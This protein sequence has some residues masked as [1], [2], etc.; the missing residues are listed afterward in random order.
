[1]LSG[2]LQVAVEHDVIP[3][4]PV[5]SLRKVSVPHA[6]EKVP[7]APVELEALV[8]GFRGR[9]RAITV[10]GGHLGLSPIEIRLAPWGNLAPGYSTLLIGAGKTKKQRAHSR[11]IVIPQATAVELRRWRMESGRPAD[12]EPII[13]PMTPRN[14][15]ASGYA[16]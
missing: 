2:I 7:L 12:T 8:A 9:E 16:S 14:L 5:R 11:V 6:D 13:G 1:M 15:R 4:N 3:A 10:L